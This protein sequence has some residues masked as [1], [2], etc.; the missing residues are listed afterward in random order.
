MSD[1]NTPAWVTVDAD[2]KRVSELAGELSLP[3]PVARILVSR[4]FGSAAAAR[5]FMDPRLDKLEDP[6]KL[7]G[8]KTAVERIW[9]AID[10]GEKITVFGDYDA[11][12]VTGTAM[13][14]LVLQKLGASVESYLPSRKDEGYGLSVE[15]VSS[16]IEQTEPKLIITV[17][18]GTNSG[19]A[20][21]HAGKQGV[22]VIIT[23]HHECIGDLPAKALAVVNPKIKG[24]DATRSLAG[25]GVAYKLCMGLLKLGKKNRKKV[26]AEVDLSEHLDLVALGTV[27]DVVPLTGDNRILVRHGLA[28]VNHTTRCGMLALIRAAGV[29]TK[30]DCYH[31]GFLIGPRINA[32]GR[33]ASADL[34]IRLLLCENPGKAK[35]LAGQLDS[36]NRERKMIEDRIIEQVAEDIDKT[37]DPK[38]TSSIVIADKGWHIG[39]IGIVAA[40]LC[41]RYKRPAIV[42]SFDA[43]GMGRGSCRSTAAVNIMQALDDCSELL[44]Q[45]GGDRLSAGISITKKNLKK[46][47]KSFHAAC[48]SQIDPADIVDTISIDS[49]I[50]LDQANKQLLEAMEALRPLGTG[51][52]TPLFGARNL[53]VIGKPRIV[54][55]NHLKLT[56]G[57]GERDID[58]IAFGMG[59]YELGKGKLDSVFQV[60]ENNYMGEKT[61]QLN[62]RDFRPAKSE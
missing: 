20:A 40:R 14:V 5:D 25:I 50:T 29:R 27:A 45:Y 33:L 47:I 39:A 42:I 54:G 31:L 10:S 4:G 11:D 7:D 21:A 61:I 53:S 44:E 41:G 52:Q 55:K 23:D 19:P 9:Q 38:K 48:C 24:S 6:Y 15:G 57:D 37:F 58:A 60:Q 2:E 12:G 51:N 18:C 56:L 46:F 22:D 49:W 17:D 1:N 59:D 30:I 36:A 43:D 13:M 35:R 28:K 34:A 62:I 26:V 32:A 8:I 3:L 16:A